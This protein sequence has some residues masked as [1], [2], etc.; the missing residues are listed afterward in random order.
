MSS[1]PRT[2]GPGEVDAAG[3]EAP[4]LRL[5]FE[6][7]PSLNLAMQ[8]NGVS[9]LRG[10]TL[11]NPGAVE[12]RDILVRI[13]AEPEFAETL[14]LR[15]AVLPPRG[16]HAWSAPVAGVVTLVGAGS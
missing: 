3:D 15:L 14:E 5:E 11:E 4:G 12:V 8:Q 6:L 10:L 2:P 7:D 13:R 9:P 16:R 1:S